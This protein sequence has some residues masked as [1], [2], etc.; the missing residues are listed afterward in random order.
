M[1]QK[2]TETSTFLPVF[3]FVLS[4]IC[5]SIPVCRQCP[6]SLLRRRFI[7]KQFSPS[8]HAFSLCCTFHQIDSLLP[9][10]WSASISKLYNNLVTLLTTPHTTTRRIPTTTA[11]ATDSRAAVY[12]GCMESRS[13]LRP[14]LPPPTFRYHH[15]TLSQIQPAP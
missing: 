9:V 14:L 2:G 13:P 5:L 1:L 10:T 12:L 7:H 6:I 11:T 8:Q 4:T 15:I 3:C